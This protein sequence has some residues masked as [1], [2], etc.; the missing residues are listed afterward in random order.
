VNF[1]GTSVTNVGGEDRCAIRASGNVDKVVRSSTG[2]YVVHFSTALPDANYAYFGTAG[3][4]VGKDTYIMPFPD[5]S[6]SLTTTSF[7]IVVFNQTGAAVSNEPFVL[8]SV[9]R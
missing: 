8:L 5:G 9:I 3:K 1:D 4:T 6:A 7:S 2:V